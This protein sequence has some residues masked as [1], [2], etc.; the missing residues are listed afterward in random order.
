MSRSS[1]LLR[2]LRW[3]AIL[4]PAAVYLLLLT[5]LALLLRPWPARRR[6]TYWQPRPHRDDLASYLR[7]S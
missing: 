6:E 5:P 2:P 4:A 7:T 3:L 1:W